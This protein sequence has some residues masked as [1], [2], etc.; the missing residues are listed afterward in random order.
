MKKEKLYEIFTDASFDS[1]T[2]IA[3]YAIVI[4]QEKKIIKA[5]AKKCKIQLEN[6]TECEI[7]AIFQ[8]INIIEANII[9]KKAFKSLK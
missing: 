1:K 2:K 6:S 8:A 5:F 4:I 3:T 7:F 9:K